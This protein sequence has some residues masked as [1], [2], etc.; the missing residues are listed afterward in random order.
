MNQPPLQ[1][2]FRQCGKPFTKTLFADAPTQGTSH[3]RKAVC[4]YTAYQ[5]R[6]LQ[7]HHLPCTGN[8]D[9]QATARR[10]TVKCTLGW[11]FASNI[12]IFS[13]AG[14]AVVSMQAY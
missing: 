11:F 3:R 9:F 5:M 6:M 7:Q 8:T 2:N 4:T 10:A 12:K 14:C 13:S 1:E